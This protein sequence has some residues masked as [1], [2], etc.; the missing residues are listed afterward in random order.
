MQIR[1]QIPF[2]QSFFNQ[3]V[4]FVTPF[5]IDMTNC[6]NCGIGLITLSCEPKYHIPQ[7]LAA[8]K[9]MLHTT[10]LRKRNCLAGF[11]SIPSMHS[12]HKSIRYES[13]G[14]RVA[15]AAMA[16]ITSSL[17]STSPTFASPTSIY[18][19]CC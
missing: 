11:L 14:E 13:D 9:L 10:P 7:N 16:F 5:C 2:F 18:C 1:I 19:K 8:V 12:S 17:C 15:L 3:F 6:I 4:I